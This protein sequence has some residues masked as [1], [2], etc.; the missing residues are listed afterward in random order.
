MSDSRRVMTA[1]LLTSLLAAAA[2]AAPAFAD[3]GVKAVERTFLERA[4]ITAA[5]KN[6]NL[7]T[8][9]ERLALRSGL[10]QSEG[11]LL[12]AGKDPREIAS[13][14]EEVRVHAKALGCGHPSVMEVAATIRSSYRQFAKTNSLDYSAK[15]STWQTSRSKH[16]IWS[17]MQIDKKSGVIIGLR[18]EDPE[19]PE[20]FTFAIAVPYDDKPSSIV[21]LYLRDAKKMADP[22]LGKLITAR[23]EMQ[24]A[25]RSVSRPEWAGK[26]VEWEDNV[27][28]WYNVYFLSKSSVERL[29]LLDPREAIE[30]ELTPNARAKVKAPKK[31]VFEIGDFR[32]ARAFAMIPA[33]VYAATP[34]TAAA[35]APKAGGH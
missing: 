21:Q 15:N 10:Y 22:W 5:D 12:R 25:A 31:I 28:D 11:E 3:P 24:P 35:A 20:E 29:E 2:L 19:K 23:G 34:E 9:G 1:R 14:T 27:G 30:V 16:D 33:P 7:F 4:A 26:M 18:R 6:C 13:I 32:A 17:V 8:D